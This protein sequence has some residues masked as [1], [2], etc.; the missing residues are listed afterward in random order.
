[1]S[2]EIVVYL[3]PASVFD[4]VL[5]PCCY[6]GSGAEKETLFVFYSYFLPLFFLEEL[7]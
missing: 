1:M 2:G 3:V 7:S 6:A 4:R 5:C